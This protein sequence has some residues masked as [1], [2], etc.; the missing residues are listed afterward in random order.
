MAA[1][2]NSKYLNQYPSICF[3]DKYHFKRLEN[4]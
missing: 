3:S 4:D 1:F 2:S